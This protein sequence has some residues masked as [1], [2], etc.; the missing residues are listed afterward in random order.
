MQKLA[1]QQPLPSFCSTCARVPASARYGRPNMA[2]ATRKT[3]DAHALLSFDER[4]PDAPVRTYAFGSSLG[5]AGCLTIM[6]RVHGVVSRSMEG[7]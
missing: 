7:Q 2:G 5:L 4:I 1:T 6:S 3:D